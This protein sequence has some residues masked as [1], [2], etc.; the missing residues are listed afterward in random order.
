MHD[1][2]LMHSERS[3]ILSPAGGGTRLMQTGNYRGLF[4]HFPPKTISRIQVSFETIDQAI[5]QRAEGSG[6]RRT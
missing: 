4:T 6:A 3:F 2:G 1:P 5:K